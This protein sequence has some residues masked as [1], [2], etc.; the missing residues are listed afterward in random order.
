MDYEYYYN[1]ARNR[2]YNACSEINVCENRINEL[3]GQEVQKVNQINQLSTDIR[4]NREALEGLEQIIRVEPVLNEKLVRINR[5]I[6][7]AAVNYSGMVSSSNVVNK[8]LNDIYNDGNAKNTLNSVLE[9]LKIRKNSVAARVEELQSKLQQANSNL[10]EIQNAI[11]STE[12]SLQSWQ[13]V[14][15]NAS[16]DMEY[17]RRKMNQGL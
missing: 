10:Q 8:N 3:R 5:H 4:N 17:Y 1:N 7:Q 9:N 16:I 2:Y 13:G 14:K 15:T 12:S 11:R 6:S